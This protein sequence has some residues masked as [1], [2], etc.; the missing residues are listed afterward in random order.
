MELRGGV[1]VKV[2]RLLLQPP[3]V[4]HPVKCLGLDG[5]ARSGVRQGAA[6]GGRPRPRSPPRPRRSARPARPA[7]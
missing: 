7:T 4:H 2:Q 6:A 1:C 5:A 3:H